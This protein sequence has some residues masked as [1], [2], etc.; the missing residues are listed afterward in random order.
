VTAG[1]TNLFS[2]RMQSEEARTELRISLKTYTSTGEFS[3]A[4][5]TYST[6]FLLTI[7]VL[8]HAQVDSVDILIS[9]IHN[10]QVKLDLGYLG[11]SIRLDE[12]ANDAYKLVELGNKTSEKLIDLLTSD[13][14]GIIAHFLLTHIHNKPNYN[15]LKN[16][17]QGRFIYNGLEIELTEQFQFT[18]KRENLKKC[19]EDWI[20]KLDN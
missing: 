6:I 5:K 9:N 17:G 8:C 14:K 12:K 19:K 10:G 4:M 2:L 15:H 18:A 11:Y 20:K 13:D 3:R 7:S 16:E 1:N